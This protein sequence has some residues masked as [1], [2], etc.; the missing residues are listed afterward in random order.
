ME[1]LNKSTY[2]KKTSPYAMYST[3]ISY[4]S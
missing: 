1:H 3:T 4:Y 2:K